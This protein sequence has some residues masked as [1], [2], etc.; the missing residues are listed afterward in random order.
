[1]TIVT[2]FL[3][4]VF[5]ILTLAIFYQL[6]SKIIDPDTNTGLIFQ[7]LKNL[8]FYIP[9]LFIDLIEFLKHQFK[10]TSKTV[11][12]ILAIQIIVI[13]L[14]FLIP[15]LYSLY[16]K[17]NIFDNRLILQEEPIYLNKETNVGIFQEEE[18]KKNKNFN[19][20]FAVSCKIWINPQPPNY[21]FKLW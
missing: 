4:I 10:I 15:Y 7:L 11:W 2:S 13:I 19:Y 3:N 18:K 12:I 16:R 6:F 21:S 17:Y 9:C 20:R 5:I 8:I 14:R 1:M